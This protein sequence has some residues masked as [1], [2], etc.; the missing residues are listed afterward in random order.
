MNIRNVKIFL[1]V[2]ITLFLSGCSEPRTEDY[3]MQKENWEKADQAAFYCEGRTAFAPKVDPEFNKKNECG[4]IEKIYPQIRTNLEKLKIEKE[5]ILKVKSKWMYCTE[6]YYPYSDKENCSWVNDLMK[7][8]VNEVA[9]EL[10]SWAEDQINEQNDIC[11]SEMHF[12]KPDE[13]KYFCVAVAYYYNN[14]IENKDKDEI[15]AWKKK[16]NEYSA[17]SKIEYQSKIKTPCG[18]RAGKAAILYNQRM[19]AEENTIY[20]WSDCKAWVNAG[21]KLR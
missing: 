13:D 14:I 19:R 6:S 20:N 2:F 7:L 8:K 5:S 17:L 1:A 3:W 4:I 12:A 15:L 11:R 9:P 21:K 18:T 16:V 10:S